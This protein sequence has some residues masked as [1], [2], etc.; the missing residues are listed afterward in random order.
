[1]W[2]FKGTIYAKGLQSSKG[3]TWLL[4]MKRHQVNAR[5]SKVLN[6]DRH[7]PNPPSLN[8]F[9][10]QCRDWVNRVGLT[11]LNKDKKNNSY[12]YPF[13]CF[14]EGSFVLMWK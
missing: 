7:D 11:W 3:P 9:M 12:S 4:N 2:L 13:A 10:T 6:A 1:M 5:Q 14:E 8:R